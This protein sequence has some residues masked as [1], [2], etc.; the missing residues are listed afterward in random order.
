[1]KLFLSFWGQ[2]MLFKVLLFLALV[3]ILLRGA[4]SFG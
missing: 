3:A 4:K 2:Q 1:M